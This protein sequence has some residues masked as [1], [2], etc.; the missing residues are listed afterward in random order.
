M[1]VIKTVVLDIAIQWLLM[2]AK[3]EYKRVKEKY[4]R[5]ASTISNKQNVKIAFTDAE[6]YLLKYLN[7]NKYITA[8]EFINNTK[9]CNIY[10][11]IDQNSSSA[12]VLS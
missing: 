10:L 1:L 3:A 12:G 5:I 7:E 2:R 8:K 6:M 9:I 4:N 11:L